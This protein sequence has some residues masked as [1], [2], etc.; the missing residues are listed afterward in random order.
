MTKSIW[1]RR[2]SRGLICIRFDILTLLNLSNYRNEELKWP[3]WS[4]FDNLTES[5][6]QI[7]GFCQ[8]IETGSRGSFWFFVS[9]IWQIQKCQ[10]IETNAYQATWQSPLSNGFCQIPLIAPYLFSIY[11]RA[12]NTYQRKYHLCSTVGM[13]SRLEGRSKIG[14]HLF[15]GGSTFGCPTW[16]LV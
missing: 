8:I 7:A 9:I 14:Y 5:A 15:I 6:N 1:K 3:T 16:Y 12:A 13:Y 11:I 10:N 2:L 4:R